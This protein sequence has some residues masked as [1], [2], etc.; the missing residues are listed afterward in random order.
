M[1]L[2]SIPKTKKNKN[3]NILTGITS[4][5]KIFKKNTVYWKLNISK[6]GKLVILVIETWLDDIK[7]IPFSSF[8]QHK[9]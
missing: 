1:T 7:H 2:S 5:S 9:M 8:L 4:V 6:H 3:K